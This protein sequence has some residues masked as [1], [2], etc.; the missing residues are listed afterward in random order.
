MHLI[1]SR[2]GLIGASL[3][4]LLIAAVL[5]SSGADSAALREAELWRH[6]ILGKAYFEDPDSREKSVSELKQALD[7]AP[8]SVRERVNY[9]LALLRNFKV[10]E[11][12]QQLELAKKQDPK[13]PHIWFNLG[14]A[15]RRLT[16]YPQAIEQFKQMIRLVPDEPV[17]HYALGFIYML[18]NA[19]NAAL[20]EFSAAAKLDPRMVAPHFQL[21][22]TYRKV[23]RDQDA[24]RELAIFQQLKKQQTEAGDTEDMEWSFYAEIYDPIQARTPVPSSSPVELR[25]AETALAQAAGPGPSGLALI[26]FDNDGHTDLL[27]W[28]AG[29]V[30]LYRRGSELVERTG[31]E[32]LRNVV[33]VA[34]GDFDN[35]GFS[36]LC[37][38]SDSGV[39]LF[40]NHGGHFDADTRLSPFALSMRFTRA[41]WIDYDHDNDLDLFLIG[42]KPVL[43][44]NQ[45][46]AGFTDQTSAFPFAKG[47]PLDAVVFRVV[48]DMKGFDWVVSYQDHAGV[49]YRDLLRG[50]YEAVAMTSLPAG[51]RSLQAVDF[52]NDSWMDVAFS[53][54]NGA[55]VLRSRGGKFE[56]LNSYPAVAGAIAFADLDGR[57]YSDLVTARGIVRNEQLQKAPAKF[58]M[59]WPLETAEAWA[60]ADFDGDGRV[61][62][63][64]VRSDGA[65]SLERNRTESKAHWLEV[66]LNGVKNAKLAPGAEVEIRSGSHYQK[67]LYEGVP[68]WFGV[69]DSATVDAVRITWPNGMIQSVTNQPSDRTAIYKEA[70]RMS[71]SCPMI[72]TWNGQHF[73]FITDVLGVAPLGASSGDGEYFPVDHDEYVTI[74]GRQLVAHN[75]KYDVRIAEELQEVS[76][77]DHVKLIAVDHRAGTEILTNEKFHSPPF[78]EFK[79]YG[80]NQRIYPKRAVDQQGAN[81]LPRLLSRDQTYP[82]SFRRNAAGVAELHNLDLDFGRGAAP[83]GQAI[84][85]LNGWVDWA[86]G[87]TFMGAAQERK[88]GLQ[89]PYLQVKDRAGQW[90]T[91]IDELG[92][93][94]GKPKTMVVD[95]TGKFLSE[96]REVRIVTDLCVYWDEIFISEQTGAPDVRMTDVNVASAEVRF[97]GFSTPTIHPQRKQ[98]ETF[99]YG[100]LTGSAPW[101]PT[102]GRY[103]RYG[104]V[105]EL[106]SGIDDRMVIMGAGDEIA[107]SFEALSLPQLPTGWTRDFLLLV[108]GWAKDGDANTAFSQTVEPL[109]F[110]G[111]TRY[112]YPAN[113]N[114][115]GDAAHADYRRRY[116]TR[117]G[118]HL[119]TTLH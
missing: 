44:R 49:L 95:L 110:H 59:T 115:P 10:E 101:N 27:S 42:P 12:V 39:S 102:P 63:A 75:G 25:F 51:A 93:P 70:P 85:L 68:L 5:L 116:N 61:D 100:R 4:A 118:F 56:P 9:G 80:V 83:S 2:R 43:L 21:F 92:I 111:M 54:A 53:G 79:L 14:I 22:N 62:L 66:K 52:D 89:M 7:L 45:G 108:D 1:S 72:F 77:L 74:P 78:P 73:E 112:P 91:V 103:T 16:K 113:E 82:D 107:L 98:P 106:L 33:W 40:A 34:V 90:K 20:T 30:R 11:A 87:S 15:Y 105:R 69:N 50:Q 86:D 60:A 97:R 94:A 109:P 17:T 6:R 23:G 24:A 119:M 13:I 37:V 65:V 46:A 96:S 71:G 55:M 8:K 18:T 26:D 38:L 64:V 88:G 47:V 41:L 67:K 104:D 76:Y 99:E 57:G 35:D 19:N 114:Y 31:L 36:D 81:V 84:L 28:S 3:I 58:S 32:G 48:P 29:G 117:P